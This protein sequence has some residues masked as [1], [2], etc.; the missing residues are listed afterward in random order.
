M[1]GEHQNAFTWQPTRAAGLRRLQDFLP[2]AAQTYARQR[3]YD[4]RHASAVSCLSPWVR[5]RLITEHEILQQV[6]S[7]WPLQNSEKFVQEVFWRGYF[8]G[9]LQHHPTVW[10]TY[11]EALPDLIDHHGSSADYRDAVEGRTGIDC[12]DHWT[13]ELVETGYMHNHARMWFASIWI[14][15]LRL[16]WQLGADFFL[17]HLMDGDPASNTLSWRWVGGLHTKGKTYLARADNIAKFTD[18]RFN[19]AGQLSEEAP[20]LEEGCEHPR[21]TGLSLGDPLPA[22]PFLLLLTEDDLEFA[23]SLS[24]PPADT[25]VLGA[26]ERGSP[27]A[28]GRVAQTFRHAALSDAAL[29]WADDQSHSLSSE[30]D[31][32]SRAQSLGVRDVVTS[33][34]PVGP[35]ADRLANLRQA[36]SREG[37]TLHFVQ[38][39]YDAAIWPHASKGFFALKKK[40]PQLLEQLKIP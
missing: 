24:S 37:I 22:S 10:S 18:G 38:R 16:P 27:L 15:T 33:F 26:A 32:V 36:L 11:H 3:N 35:N 12:F 19:P 8:K 31:I 21:L 13:R 25:L 29:R 39:T 1:D 5:H 4:G 6:L 40:I 9:W 20:A 23:A 2:H 34:A 30:N 17:R 7:S 14:F 28:T